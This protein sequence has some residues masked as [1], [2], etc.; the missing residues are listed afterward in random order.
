MPPEV[1]S[2]HYRPVAATDV[3]AVARTF[4]AAWQDPEIPRRQYES[5]VK[6]ELEDLKRGKWSAPFKAL[7]DIFGNMRG[8]NQEW[9]LLDVGASSGYYLDVLRAIGF[10]G[11][12]TALDM[13]PY[14]GDLARE[15]YPEIDFKVGSATELPF[16][17]K[18]FD[19]LLHGACIM[20]TRDYHKAIREA[21]R[22]A[23][24]IVVFHRT[25]IYLDDTRTQ[26][27]MKTAYGVP[28]L[29]IF[30]NED[31]IL[32]SFVNSGLKLVSSVDV[33]RDGNFAHR[34]YLLNVGF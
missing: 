19:I 29:E 14:Y 1:I 15:L 4:E 23:R 32:G 5:V 2:G 21:A 17:D 20:C 11:A 27:F 16:E 13:S 8:I 12:Y 31:E 30:F 3:D 28:S 6:Q 24:H 26:F 34:S 33:F 7:R 22:V 10:R 18:S 25:P 9:S